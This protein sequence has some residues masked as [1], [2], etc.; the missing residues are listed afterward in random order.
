[1]QFKGAAG[2]WLQSIEHLLKDLNWSSFCALIHERFSRDQHELILRQLCNI[3]QSSSVA[4]YVDRFTELV[5]QLKAYNPNP[6]KLYLVTRF[7][8]G[9]RDDIRSV[10]LV[11]RPD[12]LDAACTLA[13]LQEE[14]GDQ[15]R[16]RDARKPEGAATSKFVRS[17]PGAPWQ[18]QSVAPA[19]GDDKKPIEGRPSHQRP[20]LD[21]K[22][23]SMRNCRKARGLCMRCGEKWQPGHKCSPALQ[24]HVLQE[25]WDLCHED[26]S[27]SGDEV[28]TPA[29]PTQQAFML[30][31]TAA[32]SGVSAPRT[33]QLWGKIHD[34]DISILV[35][36]GS[37]HSFLSTS[38][39]SIVP[40]VKPM[41]KTVQ[42][43]VADGNSVP[44][45]SEIPL[46]VW[47]VQGFEFHSNLKL[48]PL[49]G[50]DMILGMD[51]LEAFSPMK[52]HWANKWISIPY[53]DRQILLQGLL[54]E[55]PTAQLLQLLHVASTDSVA[56]P[57]VSPEI[58]SLLDQFSELFAVPQGLPPR[59]QCD[60]KMNSV[61]VQ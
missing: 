48:L 14:A 16:R 37:S 57:P 28:E 17:T 1:M 34:R 4:D 19:A 18:R 38:L 43:K 23:Q 27:E 40:G 25:V 21:D 32:T 49:G 36:S 30:L 13:L 44:C 3:R 55:Q 15:G 47:S 29:E 22:L 61:A 11:Q 58:Q 26:L 5:D 2:R 39:A 60:H 59:R 45:S 20:T 50:F 31:S 42:V 35:D 10:I 9:L 53:G 8:D 6:D 56:A 52:V 54:P 41:S 7:V 12:T 51:W 46:A 33:L 24:L